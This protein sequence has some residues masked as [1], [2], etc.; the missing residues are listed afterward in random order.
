MMKAIFKFFWIFIIIISPDVNN[1][2]YAQNLFDASAGIGVLELLNAGVRYQLNRDIQIG[3][4]LG[5][6]PTSD[7]SIISISGN[8]YYHFAGSSKL[9]NQPPWY[10]K[11][12]INYLK[13]ESDKILEKYLFFDLLLGRDINLTK[14][15]GIKIDVGCGFQV[16]KKFE[17]KI[18]SDLNFN[19]DI[20]FIPCMGIEVF[21][22]I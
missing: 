16:I 7:E 2:C 21:G 4:K 13:G 5:T 17:Q 8:V 10:G 9:S 3:L 20:P 15:L 18:H 22:R 6:F 19:F 11:I 1:Q 12:G 14:R